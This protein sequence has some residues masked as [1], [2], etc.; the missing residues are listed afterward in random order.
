[1]SVAL[2][3]LLIGCSSQD[4]N[5]NKELTIK[6]PGGVQSFKEKNTTLEAVDEK[7]IES[8]KN[9]L[10]EDVLKENPDYSND[11]LE[12]RWAEVQDVVLDRT[13]KNIFKVKI[14]DQQ[15]KDILIL[16]NDKR[17]LSELKK[18][19]NIVVVTPKMW[20]E[21]AP[22]QNTTLKLVIL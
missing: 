4:I 9:S 19:H 11:A 3:F 22:P 7:K 15:S 10:I 5:N 8:L 16:R 18:G 1:M 21:S 6:R 13:S 12:S 17:N 20:L 14:I 2:V